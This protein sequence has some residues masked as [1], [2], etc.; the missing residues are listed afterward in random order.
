M[1]SFEYTTAVVTHGLL[2][3]TRDEIDP[4]ALAQALNEY[5]AQG[6]ELVKVLTDQAIHG[7]KDGH[8]LIFKRAA[9]A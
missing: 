9:G 2:G 8:L 5:G 7:G 6:W 1:A 4:D 3:R